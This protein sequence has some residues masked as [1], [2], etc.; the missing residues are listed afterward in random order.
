MR[1]A[2]LG[3]QKCEIQAHTAPGQTPDPAGEMGCGGE[4][5]SRIRLK[6]KEHGLSTY[7]VPAFVHSGPQGECQSPHWQL[8]KQKLRYVQI[9]CPGV[10]DCTARD[11]IRSL[12]LCHTSP[13][14]A[15]DY[16]CF[17]PRE[18]KAIHRF[19]PIRA[20][21]SGVFRAPPLHR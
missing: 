1:T 18:T 5:C 19:F 3:R 11:Q 4:A 8:R 13:D 16:F 14:Q 17:P 12:S 21:S 9:L 15:G 2:P 7:C 6:F 10:P 20:G